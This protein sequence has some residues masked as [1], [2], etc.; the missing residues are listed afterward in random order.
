MARLVPRAHAHGGSEARFTEHILDAGVQLVRVGD[1]EGAWSEIKLTQ[2]ANVVVHEL[3]V[4]D[5]QVVDG[6][7]QL[8]CERERT[9]DRELIRYVEVAVVEHRSSIASRFIAALAGLFVFD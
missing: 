1:R 8:L 3:R 7:R 2:P 9:T 6:Q 5:T 4:L